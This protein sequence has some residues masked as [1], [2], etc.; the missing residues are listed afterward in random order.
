MYRSVRV[1]IR[2]DGDFTREVDD[3]VQRIRVYFS[4]NPQI[5]NESNGFDLA[6]VIS[7]LNVAVDNFNRRG[8][9]FVLESI[10]H[11]VI[12]I[13]QYRPLHGGSSY[14]PTPQWLK[15]KHC[16]INVENGAD[17][18]CFLWSILA[19]IH[20][21]QLNKQRLYNY[22]RYENSLNV[23]GLS[24]PM[25]TKEIT[26]FEQ[27]NPDISVNVLYYDTCSSGFCVEYMSRHRAR[28]HQ[29]NLLL[30]DEADSNKRH[31]VLINNISRLLGHRTKH[32]HKTHVCYSCLHPFTN[33]SALDKHTPYCTVHDAQQ[34]VYPDPENE[35][36][37]T[38]KYRSHRKQHPIPFHLICDFESFLTPVDDDEEDEEDLRGMRVIDEH[39]ISGFCCYRVTK[40][41]SYQ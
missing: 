22:K 2:T 1:H 5:V 32:E 31:Y 29:I 40:Y 28:R 37:C 16:V 35:D 18:K 3:D 41:E 6:S 39:R 36:D 10:K 15:N 23:D 21:P 11:F 8:S 7:D 13:T 25:Q 14:I 27:Q 19:H 34:V 12:C 30:L 17:T 38:L 4:T 9:G 20:Q 24:F 26:L 33:A